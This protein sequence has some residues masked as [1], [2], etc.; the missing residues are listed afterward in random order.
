MKAYTIT[1]TSAV[2]VFDDGRMATIYRDN[3][4]FQELREAIK[5]KNDAVALEIAFPTVRATNQLSKT[6]TGQKVKIEGGVV[7]FE[8][9]PL[10]NALT[11]RM[12]RMLD[13]GF[14]ITPLALFLENLMQNPSYRAVNQLYTF[15]EKSELPITED[16][17]FLAYKKVREDFKDCHTGTM[18][19]SVGKIVEMPRNEVNEN[20]DETCSAGLH[21]CSRSY[22]S[23]FSGARTVMVKVNP[24]D[25]VSIPNDYNHSKA[26]CCRYEVI[27]EL[28]RPDGY[29]VRPIEGAFHDTGTGVKPEAAP[30][31][32]GEVASI[33]KF[34]LD[35]GME[36]GYFASVTEAAKKTGVDSSSIYK[37]LRGDRNSAGGFGW[38]YA[39]VVDAPT[40]RYDDDDAD[41]WG[42]DD[43]DGYGN[44]Y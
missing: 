35:S 6:A 15:L 20:P 19:N 28:D 16:G 7:Y 8:G 33:V 36:L 11:M 27:Q 26:R 3:P 17:H 34:A 5:S 2:L 9:K 29:N 4:R 12:V 10:H 14:D 41:E 1:D 38:R 13:E 30:E 32:V 22:L 39:R 43:D 42:D 44:Y 24:R 31:P 21:F 25:V 40:V 37:V 23:Q 18:D